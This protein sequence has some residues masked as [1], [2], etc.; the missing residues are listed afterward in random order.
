MIRLGIALT[1]ALAAAGTVA[2]TAPSTDEGQE[3]QEAQQTAPDQAK[4]EKD[5]PSADKALGFGHNLVCNFIKR[6]RCPVV[7][8][9]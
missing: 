3:G 8:I 2:C 5:G 6:R 4:D 7:D 1:L 9:E